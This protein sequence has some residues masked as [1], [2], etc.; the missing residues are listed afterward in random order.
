MPTYRVEMWAEG[1]RGNEPRTWYGWAAD[2]EAAEYKALES[3]RIGG[4]LLP[5]GLEVLEVH[6]E[7]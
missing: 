5:P 4:W 7:S 1:D 6:D 3:Q 2:R